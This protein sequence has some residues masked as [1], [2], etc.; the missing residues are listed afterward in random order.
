MV[1]N[2]VSYD[3]SFSTIFR[4]SKMAESSVEVTS[5]DG[6]GYQPLPDRLAKARL[7]MELTTMGPTANAESG[8]VK[9]SIGE[10]EEAV[11][12]SRSL[13]AAPESD[14]RA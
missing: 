11:A 7:K 4:I 2:K 12:E 9:G 6:A 10:S 5:E 3:N 13:L 1:M 14:V 8:A